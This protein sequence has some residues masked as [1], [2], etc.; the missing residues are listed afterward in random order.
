[1]QWLRTRRL[2]ITV[3][4]T[5]VLNRPAVA[6]SAGHNGETQRTA[7]GGRAAEPE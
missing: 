6:A 1:L 2:S 5:E 3:V 4:E 7:R